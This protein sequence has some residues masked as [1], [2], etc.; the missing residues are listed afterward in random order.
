MMLLFIKYLVL[1]EK[2]DQFPPIWQRVSVALQSSQ[3]TA[4][5]VTTSF[6]CWLLPFLPS[7]DRC[8]L[9]HMV[10]M[11]FCLLL[12]KEENMLK[13][14]LA[15][16][17]CLASTQYVSAFPSFFLS[18]LCSGKDRQ[19]LFNTPNPISLLKKKTSSFSLTHSLIE[20]GSG[21]YFHTFYFWCLSCFPFST[22]WR[23]AWSFIIEAV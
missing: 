9:Q 21:D 14:S 23:Q 11:L 2:N 8:C 6:L 10:T 22:S 16:R 1:L 18:F 19:W 12:F 5:T 7:L 3:Q 4:G 20:R 15:G 13:F 17:R